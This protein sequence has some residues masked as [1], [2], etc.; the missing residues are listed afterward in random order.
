MPARNRESV[1]RFGLGKDDRIHRDRDLSRVIR[2]GRVVA[3][4]RLRLHVLPNDLGSSRMAVLVSLRHGNAV[5]RN[6]I[7]RV[8][9]EAFRLCRHELPASYDYILR[10]QVGVEMVVTEVQESLRKLSKA[11]EQGLKK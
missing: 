11:A 3:D 6:R 7:K 9:R 10:P 8:C 1:L 2:E 4:R 5:Q